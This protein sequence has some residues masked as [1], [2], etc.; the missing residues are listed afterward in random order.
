[1]A[2]KELLESR[3]M[4]FHVSHVPLQHMEVYT[5]QRARAQGLGQ[6]GSHTVT[7]QMSL[8]MFPPMSV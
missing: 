3:G 2:F 5:A 1:M 4:Y 7:C 8:T 6:Q